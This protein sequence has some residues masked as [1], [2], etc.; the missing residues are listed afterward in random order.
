MGLAITHLGMH[1]IF[2]GHKYIL[3]VLRIIPLG[4]KL[5]E[6]IKI[7]DLWAISVTIDRES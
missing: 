7:R 2:K 5:R 3:Q 6:N 4:E 1:K